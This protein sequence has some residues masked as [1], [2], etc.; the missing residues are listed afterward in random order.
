MSDSR[1]RKSLAWNDLRPL[2][3]QWRICCRYRTGREQKSGDA[4]QA[5]RKI[6]ARSHSAT[7]Y[8]AGVT[9]HGS[10]LSF[11][12]YC[13]RRPII[14]HELNALRAR[15]MALFSHRRLRRQSG[16]LLLE[17]RQRSRLN[18][19]I[20]IENN[21][22]SQNEDCNG[23]NNGHGINAMLIEPCNDLGHV[24]LIRY[25]DEPQRLQAPIF[26]GTLCVSGFY[27]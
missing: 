18:T 20:T 3:R 26:N 27:P 6:P 23:I 17:H 14:V 9:G 8:E 13:S 21:D 12:R 2:A 19:R 4:K 16:L 15:Y 11:R 5:C 1:R 7:V 24:G 22:L 10:R 25:R